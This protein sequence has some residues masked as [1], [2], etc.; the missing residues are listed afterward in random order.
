MVSAAFA[1]GIVTLS[2]LFSMTPSE[3]DRMTGDLF[4]GLA[5]IESRYEQLGP[6][7]V[8]LRKFAVPE[9][10]VLL[11]ALQELRYRS[12]VSSHDYAR[13]LSYV[14][15]DDQLRFAR[16]GDRQNRLPL[17]RDR[18]GEGRALAADAGIVSKTR[19][20]C[21]PLT[22]DSRISSPMRA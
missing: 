7:A 12:A 6:G 3:N 5:E 14:S 17:R 1:R 19:N 18:S 2:A 10:M 15:R 9:E 22:Q 16:L 21:G 8:I 20:D 11:A 4:E 13:R